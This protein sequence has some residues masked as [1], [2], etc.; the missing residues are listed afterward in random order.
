MQIFI[1]MLKG[2]HITLELDE[3]KEYTI[4]EI[5]KLISDKHPIVIDKVY[6][7][8]QSKKLLENKKISDY[9]ITKDT[10]LE[11]CINWITKTSFEES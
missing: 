1:K 5:K 2:Y 6:L 11:L 8:Y 10:T 4:E 9:G 7:L 3:K